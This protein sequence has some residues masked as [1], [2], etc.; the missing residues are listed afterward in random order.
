MKV[1]KDLKF[2]DRTIV[3]KT[4]HRTYMTWLVP[5]HLAW[6][7]MNKGVKDES[8]QRNTKDSY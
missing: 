1:G 8:K 5:A 3:L 4:D 2:K 6:Q 7:Y